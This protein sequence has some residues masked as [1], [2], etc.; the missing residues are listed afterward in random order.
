MATFNRRHKFAPHI[1]G[2]VRRETF[3]FSFRTRKADPQSVSRNWIINIFTV[4]KTEEPSWQ[5]CLFCRFVG[6]LLSRIFMASEGN[7]GLT[8]CTI[9]NRQVTAS[10][11][12]DWNFVKIR[13]NI[14][15][16]CSISV[17]ADRSYFVT[18]FQERCQLHPYPNNGL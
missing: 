16:K 8:H 18:Q 14:S 2:R 12:T 6:C 5:G 7:K 13:A 17:T 3:Y 1:E 4:S 9:S 15:V 10:A 11:E